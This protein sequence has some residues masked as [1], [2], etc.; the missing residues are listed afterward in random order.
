MGKRRQYFKSEE[1]VALLRRHLI[2]GEDVSAICESVKLHPTVFYEWQKKFF[3][4]G[5]KAFDRDER[6]EN[7]ELKEKVDRLEA[8]LRKKDNALSELIEEH[9]ALKKSLGEP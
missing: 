2:E 6:H 3:E 9:I 4:N 1:K 8:K 7:S 5:V